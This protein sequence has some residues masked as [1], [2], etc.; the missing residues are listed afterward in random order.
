[1]QPLVAILIE[2]IITPVITTMTIVVMIWS[3]R[4]TSGV[5]IWSMCKIMFAGISS[6]DPCGRN[7]DHH[8]SHSMP[9][10]T[11]VLAAL[12]RKR[13]SN[14]TC[15]RVVETVAV[16]DNVWCNDLEYV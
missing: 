7:S 2:V 3:I 16:T 15:C 13:H 12:I 8:C 11:V 14:K 6:R 4:R 10:K 1:M 5:M 9:I